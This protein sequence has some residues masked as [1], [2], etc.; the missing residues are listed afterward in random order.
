MIA[1][2]RWAAG[3][4]VTYTGAQRDILPGMYIQGSGVPEAT[5]ASG[6]AGEKSGL[7]GMEYKPHQD[8]LA[9][10]IEL[11]CPTIRASLFRGVRFYSVLD[12][13]AGKAKSLQVAVHFHG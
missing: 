7:V 8:Q 10:S 5:S 12:A 11:G 4:S 9:R 6:G 2:R 3:Q 1:S 13:A